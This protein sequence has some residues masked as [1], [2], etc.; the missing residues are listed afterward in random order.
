MPCYTAL[1][2]SLLSLAQ[3]HA[4]SDEIQPQ[5]YEFEGLDVNSPNVWPHL[6]L[7]DIGLIT[8]PSDTFLS[9]LYRR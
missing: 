3:S 9:D 4:P 6:T 7:R 5:E 1:G 8:H 2:A